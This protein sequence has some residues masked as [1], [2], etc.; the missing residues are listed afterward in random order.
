V[1]IREGHRLSQRD[2]FK[3]LGRHRAVGLLPSWGTLR[4]QGSL[5]KENGEKDGT[6]H[7]ARDFARRCPAQ[8]NTSH[9]FP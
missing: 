9:S 2:P 1:E 7:R 4:N 8:E 6:R 5:F 3:H